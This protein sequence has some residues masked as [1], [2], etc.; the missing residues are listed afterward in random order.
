MRSAALVMVLC[1]LALISGSDRSFGQQ[2]KPPRTLENLLEDPAEKAPPAPPAQEPVASVNLLAVPSEAEVAEAVILIRE[3][4]ADDY[5]GEPGLSG[6]ALL[7]NKCILCNS[8]SPTQV[9][10]ICNS[11]NSKH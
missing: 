7:G 8:Y 6:K 2:P 4:Y 11:C 5:K 1:G 10:R 9:P 3:A